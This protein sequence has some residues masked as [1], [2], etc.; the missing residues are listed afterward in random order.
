MFVSEAL[1][2]LR[3]LATAAR[4]HDMG[5]RTSWAQRAQ[6]T[7][8]L[9]GLGKLPAEERPIAGRAAQQ[10][11]DELTEALRSSATAIVSKAIDVRRLE[12]DAIDITLP[13]RVPTIGAAH[14]ISTMIDELV[15]IFALLGFQAVFGP[16]VETRPLQLRPAQHPG[17]SSRARRLGH[18]PC[19][20][21]RRGN[22]APDAHLSHAGAHHGASAAA[23]AR[24]RAGSG[25]PV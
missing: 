11:R 13:G 2:S 14:P 21:R 5:M 25:L 20:D 3:P 22:R 10:L 7:M 8:L 4:S 12:S 24:D 19:A 16:E 15:D 18:Y 1:A 6:V 17:R 23:G 9:R